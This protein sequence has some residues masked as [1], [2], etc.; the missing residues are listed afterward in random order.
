MA[1]NASKHSRDIQL[2]RAASDIAGWKII[3]A[4]YAGKVEALED[5]FRSD[6]GE[7]PTPYVEAMLMRQATRSA[8]QVA[9]AASPL[10]PLPAS[11]QPT[12]RAGDTLPQALRVCLHPG[13]RHGETCTICR[14]EVVRGGG[15]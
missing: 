11:S 12:G 8:H 2:R 5:Q 7:D 9:A 1:N 14:G 13:F 4:N 10:V 3:I 15:A 6:F